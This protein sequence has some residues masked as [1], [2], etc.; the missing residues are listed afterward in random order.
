MAALKKRDVASLVSHWSESGES[1]DLDSGEATKGRDSIGRVF[2][3]LFER[4]AE[5]D[6]RI[7]VSSVRPIRDEIKA[8]VTE[9]LG[10]LGVE[11]HPLPTSP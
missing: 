10:E 8:R 1:I 6:V 11:V 2:E 5:A 7:D 4:E 3:S 9:L